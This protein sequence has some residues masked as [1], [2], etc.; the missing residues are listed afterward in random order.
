ALQKRVL[1]G[2]IQ[3]LA[4]FPAVGPER[5]LMSIVV[6][7]NRQSRAPAAAANHRNFHSSLLSFLCHPSDGWS[8]ESVCLPGQ[9]Q[10]ESGFPDTAD[11]KNGTVLRRCRK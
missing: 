11:R 9:I 6:Q 2:V 5:D 7:Q 4:L 3:R 1:P 8:G 10:S